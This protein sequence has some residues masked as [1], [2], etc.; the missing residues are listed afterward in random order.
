MRNT[1]GVTQRV[2]EGTMQVGPRH[3]G[4][5][6]APVGAAAAIL[7]TGCLLVGA[8]ALVV[9]RAS[10]RNWLALLFSINSGLGGA[11]VTLHM[12]NR[13]DIA[14]LALGALAFAGF[15]PGPAGPH[16]AWLAI[17]IGLPLAGIVVLLATGLAGRS[18]LMGGGLVLA[19]LMLGKRELRSLGYLGIAA[20]A[21][22]LVGDFATNGSRS[23]LVA[24]LVGA[25]YVLLIG[26]FIWMAIRLAA[27]SVMPGRVSHT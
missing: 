19:V 15:W 16:K 8:W 24:T 17:A 26:W 23:F 11:L 4:W 7:A 18:G 22:L 3:N 6:L 13:V 14:I 12:I 21:L 10:L 5:P 2:W 20:N 27:A 25:G 9:G 1:L